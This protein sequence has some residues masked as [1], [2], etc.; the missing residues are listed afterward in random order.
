[1]FRLTEILTFLNTDTLTKDC[2]ALKGGT[3]I[4]LTIFD[5]PRLSVDIDL[6]F[7]QN[8]GREEMLTEIERAV[9]FLYLQRVAFGGKLTHQAFGVSIDRPARF[10]FVKIKEPPQKKLKLSRV[11]VKTVLR[12]TPSSFFCL[13]SLFAF[14]GQVIDFAPSGFDSPTSYTPIKKTALPD[15]F[16]MVEL[17]GNCKTPFCRSA[18]ITNPRHAPLKTVHCTVF[19]TLRALSGF[20]SPTSYTPIK[21][22][23][24][25]TVFLWWS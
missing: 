22:P 13:S 17:R 9:R 16:F 12:A 4:N 19:L 18:R 15:G 25:Q 24:F 8:I 21:K 5:L 2:L 3:A 6:D 20:D 1:M 14:D 23:S 11:P 7:T 10:N